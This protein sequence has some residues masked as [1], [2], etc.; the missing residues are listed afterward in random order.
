MQFLNS[1]FVYR[2]SVMP[3]S[4]VIDGF[5]PTFCLFIRLFCIKCK[6]FM[7]FFSDC[8]IHFRSTCI[9]NTLTRMF[10]LHEPI[11]CL[12]FFTAIINFTTE[13][14]ASV[15]NLI[16]NTTLILFLFAIFQI[17]RLCFR[18]IVF[19]LFDEKLVIMF[20]IDLLILCEGIGFVA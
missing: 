15:S 19:E 13:P 4:V 1:V 2:R 9:L 5:V 3:S 12:M 17:F 7:S 6:I 16:T 14:T 8:F 18:S 10:M 11:C 20:P